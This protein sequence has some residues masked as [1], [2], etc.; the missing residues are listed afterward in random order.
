MGLFKC[1][2]SARNEVD[3]LLGAVG[4]S[5]YFTSWISSKIPNRI[6]LMVNHWPGWGYYCFSEGEHNSSHGHPHRV[7]RTRAPSQPCAWKLM[8]PPNAHKFSG[9]LKTWFSKLF[10][11][12]EKKETHQRESSAVPSGHSSYTTG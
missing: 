4:Y 8:S 7:V 6:P 9:F 1:V 2:P 3:G 10:G 11:R 12:S 5:H